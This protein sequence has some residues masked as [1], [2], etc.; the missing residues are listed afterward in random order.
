M[1]G[2]RVAGVVLAAG[3]STR[4]GENK[5]LLQLGGRTLVRRAVATALAGGLD[6]VLVVVGHERE[7]VEKELTGLRCTPV[8]NAEYARGIH[9]SL[10]SGIAAL[11]DETPA[12]AV[13]L[14]DMPLVTDEMVRA[15]VEAF[16]HASAPL[17]ISVY[18]EVVA[19]PIVYGK[20][21]F[22]ELRAIDGDGCGKRVVKRHRAEA[23]ELRWPEETLTDLDLPQDLERIRARLEA[24]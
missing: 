13:L 7:R 18:G 5:M 21:L 23:L 15:L 4:M 19:P 22:P 24:A 10:K 17:A 3:L 20:A 14:G 11:P 16:R 2:E 6:P 9:A 12:A 8:F 1:T